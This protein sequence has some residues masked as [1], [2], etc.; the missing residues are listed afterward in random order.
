MNE[1]KKIFPSLL[2][3][4]FLEIGVINLGLFVMLDKSFMQYIYIA[5]GILAVLNLFLHINKL[6]IDT[7]MVG[8]ASVLICYY[9]LSYRETAVEPLYFIMYVVFPAVLS[10]LDFDMER[11]LRYSAVLVVPL[12]F[13][14]NDVF[15]IEENQEI[16]SMGV[17]YAFL[18]SICAALVHYKYYRK[19]RSKYMYIAYIA[20][21]YYLIQIVQMGSRGPILAISLLIVVMSIYDYDIKGKLRINF[22][23]AFLLVI[24]TI[25]IV[26]NFLTILE[27]VQKFLNSYDISFNFIDKIVKLS[28]TDN[29]SNGRMVLYKLSLIGFLQAPIFGHGISTFAKYTN[30]VYPHNSILQLMFDGGIFLTSLVVGLFISRSVKN[31]KNTD[32]NGFTFYLF[33]FFISVPTSF[34]TG[35]LFK[36]YSFWLLVFMLMS[37]RFMKADKSD[38]IPRDIVYLP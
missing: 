25:L 14:G 35:D 26:M 13:L 1:R 9:F 22:I 38:T 10:L 17:T 24:L 31:L 19:T 3:A 20:N 29:V 5:L 33:L 28:E 12:I 23:W 18:S 32:K 37:N 36:N 16:I 34:V 4:L 8:M 7:G 27:W 15:A 2:I 6:N 11:V 21:L 30:Q